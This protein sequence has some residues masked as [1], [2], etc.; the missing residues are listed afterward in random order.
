M[1]CAI[2]DDDS[3]LQI[4]AAVTNAPAL[5][6]IQSVLVSILLLSIGNLE[7]ALAFVGNAPQACL[8]SRLARGSHM[9]DKPNL[10]HRVAAQFTPF[11]S[12]YKRF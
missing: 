10:V 7:D 4:I 5:S 9:P 8:E 3:S 12:R 1:T 2:V 6:T 11:S